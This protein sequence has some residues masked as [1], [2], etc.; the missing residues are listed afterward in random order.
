MQSPLRLIIALVLLALPLLEIAVL[1][2]AGQAF[3][4][5]PV[6]LTVI[7]TGFLGA[8]VIQTQG[9]ATFRR[10]SDA[11]E[12]GREPHRELA[13]GALRLFAGLMLLLPGLLT[14]T[15]GLLLMVPPLRALIANLVFARAVIFG[16]SVRRTTRRRWPAGEQGPQR[17]T[18]SR[19][20]E[21]HDRQFPSDGQIIEG[22]FER[23]D[24]RTVDPSRPPPRQPPKS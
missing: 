13:D 4:F 8:K 15:I 3:G 18:A 17:D 11:L 5:W 9:M 10:I 24:E 20:A 16:S 7:A 2:K 22:E 19:H 6:V 23:I 1:I 14:D 12:A 21:R